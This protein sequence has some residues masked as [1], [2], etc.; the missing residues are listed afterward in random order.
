MTN[1]RHIEYIQCFQQQR[2][3]S[4]ENCA[5]GLEAAEVPSRVQGLQGAKPLKNLKCRALGGLKISYPDIKNLPTILNTY[6]LFFFWTLTERTDF[7]KNT[8]DWKH[9]MYIR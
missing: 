4:K 8:D 3:K 2:M 9:C 6:D 5:G 7:R 1:N